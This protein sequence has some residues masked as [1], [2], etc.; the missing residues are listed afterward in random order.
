MRYLLTFALVLAL[1]ALLLPSCGGGEGGEEANPQLSLTDT[2]DQVRAGA[3]LIMSYDQTAN[4]FT[5]TVENTTGGPITNVRIEIHLS[6]G[7]ELGPT[8]GIDL[9]AGETRPVELRVDSEP[10]G[11]PFDFWSAHPEVGA[12]GTGAG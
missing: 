10:D 5:G 3:R 6:N 11:G 8:P 4:A 9:A 7:V 12:Q 1:A 2:F